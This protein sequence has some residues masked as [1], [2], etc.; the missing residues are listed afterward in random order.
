[1]PK[2]TLKETEDAGYELSRTAG[3]ILALGELFQQQHTD[4][5][6]D[7]ET[8]YGFGSLIISLGKRVKTT[9]D[10]MMYGPPSDETETEDSEDESED[11]EETEKGEESK[12]DDDSEDEEQETPFTRILKGFVKTM[13][14]MREEDAEKALQK[15][16]AKKRDKK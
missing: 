14:D 2:L 5:C 11:E 13:E 4:P 12:E 16:I 1:M 3:E 10:L 8:T 6:Y 15:R 9:S 7:G